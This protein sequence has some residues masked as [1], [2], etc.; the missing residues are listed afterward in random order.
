MP[1]R[2]ETL[3][4]SARGTCPVL[5]ETGCGKLVYMGANFNGR[6]V[7]VRECD[8]GGNLPACQILATFGHRLVL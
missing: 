7:A 8:L 4:P 2:S 3:W 1:L 5:T 6:V